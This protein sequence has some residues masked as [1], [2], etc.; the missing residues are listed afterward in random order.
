MT[1][2]QH[3]L[4]L[5]LLLLLSHL[6]ACVVVQSCH[7]TGEAA[8]AQHLEQG[9]TCANLHTQPYT[10]PD[11]PYAVSNRQLRLLLLL[12]MAETAGMSSTV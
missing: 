10:T 4:L 8:T 11:T 9:V 12:A 1:T 6:F 5:L 7:H 3:L 2:R